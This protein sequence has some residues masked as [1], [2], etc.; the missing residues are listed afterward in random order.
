M[1]TYLGNATSCMLLCVCGI[2]VLYVFPPRE[3]NI[4]SFGTYFITIFSGLLAIVYFIFYFLLY[5]NILKI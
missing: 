1:D 2:L 3:R 4:L 5:F